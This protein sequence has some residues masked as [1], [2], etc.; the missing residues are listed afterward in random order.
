M[1]VL[2]EGEGKQKQEITTC[3]PALPE[4]PSCVTSRDQPGPSRA[5]QLAR[6]SRVRLLRGGGAAEHANVETVGSNGKRQF[7]AKPEISSDPYASKHLPNRPGMC[8][9]SFDFE[10]WLNLKGTG[11]KSRPP[12]LSGVKSGV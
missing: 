5:G 2:L 3:P 12:S 4:T 9:S 11:M 10:V 1:A 6:C 7:Q 8:D